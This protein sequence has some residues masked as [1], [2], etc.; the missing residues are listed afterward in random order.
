MEDNFAPDGGSGDGSA[1]M[2]EMGRGGEWQ[3]K[4]INGIFMNGMEYL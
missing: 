1:V 2:R 4:L 3:L